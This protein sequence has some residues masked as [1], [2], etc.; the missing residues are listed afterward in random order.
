MTR[1]VGSVY[2]LQEDEYLQLYIPATIARDRHWPFAPGDGFAVEIVDR[3][4]AVV[5]TSVDQEVADA[6]LEL[7]RADQ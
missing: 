4:G 5:L 3:V 6:S 2:G 1:P 7:R